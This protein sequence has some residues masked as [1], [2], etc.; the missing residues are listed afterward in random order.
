VKY[1]RG[2]QGR[3]QKFLKAVNQVSLDSHKGLKQDVPTRWNSTYLMLESAIYYRSAFSYLEMTDSN[4]KHCPTTVEWEKVDNICSFLACFY[5]ATC[6]FSGTKYPTA[7][8]YFPVI[9]MIYVSL[10]EKLMGEDEHKKLMAIQMISK[11]E[12]YWLEF[13]EVLA[14]AVI[15]DPRYK[16]HL[17]NYYY[18]KIYGVMDSP[19]FLNVRE[20]LKSLFMEYSAS[21]NISSSSSTTSQRPQVPRAKLAWQKVNNIIN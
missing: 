15:L 14:I 20:K 7:N 2:S 19:Q 13:S 9:T 4:Y 17:V 12:K 11:F 1:V 16:L 10:K 18:T 8:L 6:V 21:F 3:K 5:E